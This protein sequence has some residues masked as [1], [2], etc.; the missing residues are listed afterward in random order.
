MADDKGVRVARLD[1][2]E[3]VQTVNLKEQKDNKIYQCAY[4]ADLAKLEGWKELVAGAGAPRIPPLARSELEDLVKKLEGEVAELR[5]RR[6]LRPLARQR[7]Q[8]T[9]SL[10]SRFKAT[11]G[12]AMAR[13]RSASRGNTYGAAPTSPAAV[14]GRI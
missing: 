1:C 2:S 3:A 11:M 5:G 8:G 12:G 13:G 9:L 4:E 14:S 6:L 10:L 7:T